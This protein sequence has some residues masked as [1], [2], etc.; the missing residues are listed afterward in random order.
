MSFPFYKGM[1]VVL[2]DIQLIDLFTRDNSTNT[3]TKIRVLNFI[4]HLQT[5]PNPVKYKI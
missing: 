2:K 4:R 3:D 5:L 1:N